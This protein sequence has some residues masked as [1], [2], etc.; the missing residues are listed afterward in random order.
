METFSFDVRVWR[1]ARALDHWPSH[2]HSAKLG[3][4]SGALTPEGWGCFSPCLCTSGVGVFPPSASRSL[5]QGA[6]H[7]HA[8]VFYQTAPGISFKRLARNDCGVCFFSLKSLSPR[9]SALRAWLRSSCH[10]LAHSPLHSVCS[11]H[12]NKEKNQVTRLTYLGAILTHSSGLEGHRKFYQ[13]LY[14]A[15]VIKEILLVNGMLALNLGSII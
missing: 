3:S 10:H 11:T 15:S 4:Q 2:G 1:K 14:V 6:F 13:L 7:H 9:R 12:F 8:I 5:S